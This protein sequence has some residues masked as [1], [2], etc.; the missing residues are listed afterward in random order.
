MKQVLVTGASGGIGYSLVQALC[1]KGHRVWAAVRKPEVMQSLQNK[2]P[3]LLTI[4]KLDMTNP[5]DLD[6]IFN[7]INSAFDSS[8]EFVLVNNAGIAI[9]SPVESLPMDEWRNLYEV[10]LFGPIRFIQKFLPLIRKSKGRIVNVGS[11]SGR[12]AAP[13]LAP[14]S[15]SKFALRA[16]SDSLR[17]ELIQLGVKVILIEPGPTKTKIWSKSLAH[18][19][20]LETK[21]SDEMRAV[22]GKQVQ[23]LRSGVESTEKNAIAVEIVIDRMMDAIE[24]KNP[25]IYYLVGKN[26]CLISLIAKFMPTRILDKL[27]MSG[28]RGEKG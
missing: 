18:G 11:I 10:N 21:M 19:E 27:L 28:F 8:K 12:I 4:V 16:L 6:Q 3:N 20:Q 24:S 1:E 5:S 26:I 15:T 23:S 17:R 22:Y 2:Y 9:G 13:F 14:Y 7:N 25:K